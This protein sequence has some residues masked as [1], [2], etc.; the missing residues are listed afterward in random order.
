MS[1]NVICESILIMFSLPTSIRNLYLVIPEL[2]FFSNNKFNEV[3]RII[4][5]EVGVHL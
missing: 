3:L 1:L 4:Y 5:H 2:Y